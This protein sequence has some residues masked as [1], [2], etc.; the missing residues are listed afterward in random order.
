MIPPFQAPAS[1]PL[2]ILR[3]SLSP[4]LPNYT[5]TATLLAFLAFGF[6]AL[7]HTFQNLVII[8]QTAG[9]GLG[10]WLDFQVNP[11][12]FI[13]LQNMCFEKRRWEGGGRGLYCAG[14][15]HQERGWGV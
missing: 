2:L 8:T 10:A 11:G 3:V 14:M 7:L 1:N 9:L 5:R 15:I 6:P 4:P 13:E 12:V